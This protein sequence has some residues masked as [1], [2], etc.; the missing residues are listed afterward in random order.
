MNLDEIRPWLAQC[1]LC[2]AGLSMACSCPPGDFREPMAQ[3]LAEIERLT[4][5]VEKWTADHRARAVA[6]GAVRRLCRSYT[7]EPPPLF[8][9]PGLSEHGE[10]YN[11]GTRDMAEAV[12]NALNDT[13]DE[14]GEEAP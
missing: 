8:R 2:D 12:L 1:G 14:S 3:M 5:I 6:I 13:L 7:P 9:G 4:A 11:H 10:G